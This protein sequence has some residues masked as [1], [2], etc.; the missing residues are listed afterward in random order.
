MPTTQARPAAAI[1][2]SNSPSAVRLF[3]LASECMANFREETLEGTTGWDIG[4]F[5]GNAGSPVS[6][7]S[8]RKG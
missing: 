8:L 5:K 3:L 2:K 1:A 7:S 4:G 6:P